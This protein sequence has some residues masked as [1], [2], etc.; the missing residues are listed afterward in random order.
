MTN[1]YMDVIEWNW[2]YDRYENELNT[3]YILLQGR[4]YVCKSEQYR[5]CSYW[6]DVPF[7]YILDLKGKPDQDLHRNSDNYNPVHR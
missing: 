7:L 2:S 5:M 3:Y 4:S 6:C 1:V